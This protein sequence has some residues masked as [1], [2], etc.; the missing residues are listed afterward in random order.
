MRPISSRLAADFTSTPCSAALPVATVMATG[1]ASPSAQGQEITS[2][3]TAQLRLNSSPCPR[4]IQTT[5]VT[6]A[7]IR[8]HTRAITAPY[9]AMVKPTDSA[10]MEVATASGSMALGDRSEFA[11]LCPPSSASLI[12]LMPTKDNRPKATQ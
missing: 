10:S 2:T 5:K 9:S 3:D 12:M 8:Q 1:V 6:A 7:M 4:T 11:S